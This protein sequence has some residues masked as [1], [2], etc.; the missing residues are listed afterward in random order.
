MNVIN[1]PLKETSKIKE[2]EDNVAL[3]RLISGITNQTGIIYIYMDD[4]SILYSRKSLKCSKK[5]QDKIAFPYQYYIYLHKR[6]SFQ[7]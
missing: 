4:N 6:I 5:L 3:I 1:I 2:V 7:D